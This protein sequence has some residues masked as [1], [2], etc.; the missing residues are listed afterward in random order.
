MYKNSIIENGIPIYDFTLIKISPGMRFNSRVQ[1][2]KLPAH[3]TP[4]PTRLAV[5]GWGQTSYWASEQKTIA[6]LY[7]HRKRYKKIEI[8]AYF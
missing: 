5:T 2:A 6:Y 8:I 1:A 3:N 7:I 4:I